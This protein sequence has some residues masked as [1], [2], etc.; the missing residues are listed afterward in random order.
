MKKLAL[1]LISISL[2][3]CVTLKTV[4][5]SDSSGETFTGTVSRHLVGGGGE[6]NLITQRG[7]TCSGAASKPQV[8]PNGYSCKGQEGDGEASCTDGRNLHLHWIA[9]SCDGGYGDAKFNDG[10]TASFV[11]TND[12]GELNS[13]AIF[14]KNKYEATKKFLE[15]KYSG[16]STPEVTG[17]GYDASSSDVSKLNSNLAAAP[18]AAINL[19]SAQDWNWTYFG[20][21][22]KDE[23]LV[24]MGDFTK[25]EI[26]ND[27]YHYLPY[28]IYS[29]KDKKIT[30]P[31]SWLRFYCPSKFT[32]LLGEYK[33][34]KFSDKPIRAGQGT[35]GAIPAQLFCDYS[36]GIK[37]FSVVVT[38]N[39]YTP[40]GF[41]PLDM[42]FFLSNNEKIIEAKVLDYD[43]T[44]RK[45]LA[46]RDLDLN[47][48]TQIISEKNNSSHQ[49]APYKNY[50][51]RPF[52]YFLD[53]ACSYYK[54]PPKELQTRSNE[55]KVVPTIESDSP[56]IEAR[57]LVTDAWT[58]M[59]P[60]TPEKKRNY[61]QSYEMNLHGFELHHPE[62]ASN[63]GLLY[64]KGWGVPRDV[65]SAE[66]WYLKAISYSQYHSAQAEL[67]LARIYLSKPH[68]KDNLEKAADYI[69]QAKV[70]A[71]ATNS[72]WA[73]D[74]AIYIHEADVLK[75]QIKIKN[76]TPPTTP[77]EINTVVSPKRGIHN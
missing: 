44:S 15:Y 56:S 69:E 2:S 24:F 30:S 9:T 55:N 74:Q 7:I 17:G 35:V 76:V 6:F 10:S 34:G 71:V 48:T 62:G 22:A 65:D 39:K 67:G 70:T 12:E 14:L 54:E 5:I 28:A 4:G 18:Q 13:A 26:L 32:E 47:C 40:K 33:N 53:T 31:V 21:G 16:S 68:D 75:T 29:P 77:K 20:V 52:R 60:N 72:L 1:I 46:S 3:S 58:L 36:D 64:E 43:L 42:R 63:I 49:L 51:D 59:S 45:I 11:F 25:M 8:K 38:E 23:N 37:G 73:K 41:K 50:G 61:K 57:K 27:N 19:P 66:V